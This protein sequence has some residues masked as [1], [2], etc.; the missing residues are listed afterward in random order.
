[1]S[2]P[3]PEPGRPDPLRMMVLV[4]LALLTLYG[5][6]RYVRGLLVGFPDRSGML[7][8]SQPAGSPLAVP[9]SAPAARPSA[10]APSPRP[11]SAGAPV[12]SVDTTR[13]W[14]EFAA[15]FGESLR[16]EPG[17]GGYVAAIRGLPGR[18]EMATGG[19]SSA[20]SA[21]VAARAREVLEGAREVLGIEA[22]AAFG[23]PTVRSGAGS[24]QVFFAQ[25]ADGVPLAPAGS[26]LVDLGPRGEIL[27]VSSDYVRGLHVE[28]A[29]N[30]SAEQARA[31]AEAAVPPPPGQTS[32]APGLGTLG[33]RPV[34]WVTRGG[35]DGAPVGHPAYDF[36]VG[37]HQV[38]VDAGDGQV[39]YH[40]DR[41]QF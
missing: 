6:G 40:R 27:N 31:H 41:R 3:R 35:G 36:N 2:D 14:R 21:Q 12:A 5:L 9:L 23:E 13:A 11:S 22:G 1:M 34:V 38:I 29:R 17:A 32:A 19:F 16:A 28:G 7:A 37:G 8:S 25:T 18:G 20:D 39:L 30:L 4:G 15:R 33:G 24:A 10:H 26:V